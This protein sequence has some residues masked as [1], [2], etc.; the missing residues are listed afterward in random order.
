[1]YSSPND[2]CHLPVPVIT[3][4][5]L[6]LSVDLPQPLKNLSY[7]IVNYEIANYSLMLHWEDPINGIDN[8]TVI[9]TSDN[10]SYVT[11]IEES[12]LIFSLQYNVD[13]ILSVSATNCM[14]EGEYAAINIS[15]GITLVIGF[16]THFHS[17]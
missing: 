9:L 13:Y 8:Y 7:S 12:H 5:T 10:D 15:K 14:G 4:L 6:F 3:Y 2:F 1:M 17:T 16:I 11:V